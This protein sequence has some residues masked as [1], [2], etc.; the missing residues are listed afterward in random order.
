[1]FDRVLN[2]TGFTVEG[3]QDIWLL[4]EPDCSFNGVAI[5]VRDKFRNIH[6]TDNKY[7]GFLLNARDNIWLQFDTK[8]EWVGSTS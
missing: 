4:F 3:S 5:K 1:M 8:N 2:P 6:D 7:V